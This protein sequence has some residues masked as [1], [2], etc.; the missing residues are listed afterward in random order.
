MPELEKRPDGSLRLALEEYEAELLRRLGGEMRLLLEAD[1]PAVDPVVRRLFPAA[2]EEDEDEAAYRQMIGKDLKE[3]KGQALETVTGALGDTGGA[4]VDL[5]PDD[6]DDWL[7]FLAD[8]RL[9]IGT[10]LGVDEET[11]A[12]SVDPSEP[13]AVAMSIMH[14]L[15]YVQET[16]LGYVTEG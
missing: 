13:D 14:W 3:A 4:E 7:T 15:G 12:R 1:V 2:Y 9:A 10:R 5:P 6:V 11:M 16:I 8:T